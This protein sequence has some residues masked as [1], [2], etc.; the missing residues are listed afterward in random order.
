MVLPELLDT[1]IQVRQ[2]R[3]GFLSL[4]FRG[5]LLSAL[6]EP[7]ICRIPCTPQHTCGRCA[8][9]LVPAWLEAS[10]HRQM[11]QHPN[12]SD[13]EEDEEEDARQLKLGKGASSIACRSLSTAA[14][15]PLDDHAAIAT[16]TSTAILGMRCSVRIRGHA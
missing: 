6:A 2:R 13:D 14:P 5:S 10:A 3:K 7:D 4:H 1:R 12:H 15:V 16:V 9:H 11:S 8:A